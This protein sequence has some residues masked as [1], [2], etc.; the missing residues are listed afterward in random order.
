M[1]GEILRI[2]PVAVI[3]YKKLSVGLYTQSLASRVVLKATPKLLVC[4][5]YP[6]AGFTS[7]INVAEFGRKST[8]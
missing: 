7:F 1:V 3:P 5:V 8:T 2:T 6:V 4:S